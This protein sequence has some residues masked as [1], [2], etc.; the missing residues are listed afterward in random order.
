MSE[1]SVVER[2]AHEIRNMSLSAQVGDFLGSEVSLASQFK[3][4][5]PTLRQASRL[6]EHE[7]VLVVRRGVRG[8]YFAAR[9]NVHTVSRVAATY[10]QGNLSSVDEVTRLMEALT[11]FVVNQVLISE[12][13]EELGTFGVEP[14]SQMSVDEC[15]EQEAAFNTLVCDLTGNVAMQMVLSIFFEMGLTAGFG[16]PAERAHLLKIAE[17]RVALV[18]AILRDDRDSSIR[19][20]LQRSR[21]IF[22]GIKALL[23]ISRPIA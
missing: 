6:L 3:V 1:P 4:S 16:Q 10:L 23:P 7:E 12:R 14:S 5:A 9:P 2:V 22:D 20:A 17:A 11:P 13:R 19:H 8:G 21:L 18:D 15:I